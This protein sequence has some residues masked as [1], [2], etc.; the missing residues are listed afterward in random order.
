MSVEG[1]ANIT[2]MTPETAF[3]ALKDDSTA[4]LVDVRTRPEWSFVGVPNLSGL[5]RQTALIEWRQFPD[6]S[7]N[8]S[9][10]EQVMDAAGGTMPDQIFFICRSGARSMEAAR[11]VAQFADAQGLN[12]V[13]VNVAEG[14]EGDLNHDRH[15]G[16]LNGWKARGLPWQQS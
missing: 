6:M 1:S 16:H 15:R 12:P 2:E 11:A 3:A 5:S 4:L 14:F 13:C 10:T 7:V 9:F 8:E